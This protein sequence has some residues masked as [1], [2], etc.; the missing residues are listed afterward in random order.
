MPCPP[1]ILGEDLIGSTIKN[2]ASGKLYQV[3]RL[4]ETNPVKAVCRRIVDGESYKITAETLASDYVEVPPAPTMGTILEPT[5]RHIFTNMVLHAKTMQA[6]QLGMRK[7]LNSSKLEEIWK[8]STINPCKRTSL[9]FYGPSGTGKSMA[10]ACIAKEL[11]KAL[12]QIDYPTVFS[13]TVNETARRI[14]TIFKEAQ[15]QEN[16]VLFFDEADSAFSKRVRLT[17]KTA[18]LHGNRNKTSLMNGLD[19]YSG[20]VIFATNYL[21]NFDEAMLRRVAQYVEF[22]LPDETMRVDIFHK[23]IVVPERAENIDWATIGAASAGLTGG[24][25]LNIVL[26]AISRVSAS[27]EDTSQWK[28]TTEALMAEIE[29]VAE[30][31][32]GLVSCAPTTANDTIED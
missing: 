9:C 3:L 11:G 31:K 24:D 18:I 28:L 5:D 15:E 21:S 13:P 12:F 32:K 17:S 8:I 19:N 26:N 10:A 7:V 20:V 4:T 1:A 23:H 25:I 29:N 2:T 14:Q 30:S 6:L 22:G 16:S 27:T